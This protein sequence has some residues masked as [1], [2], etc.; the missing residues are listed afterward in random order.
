MNFWIQG[1]REA[2]VRVLR[3]VDVVTI[4]E[5]EARQ[6]ANEANLIKAARRIQAMGPR[7]VVVK[8]GEYGALMLAEDGFFMVPA[9]PLESV[10]DPTGAGDTFAGGFVGYLASKNAVDAVTMRR[11][12]VD[13]SVMAS[14]TVED[15]SLDRLARLTQPEIVERYAA[16]HDLVRLPG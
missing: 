1:K 6:L 16:F 14:F 10:Y 2:L 13:G 3:E 5:G 12:L 7:T 9:Y 8:R 15:F 4:N 11:G